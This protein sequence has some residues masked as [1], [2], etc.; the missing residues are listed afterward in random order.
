MLRHVIR[1]GV[2]ILTF[3]IGVAIFWPLQ[4]IQRLET[5][6]VDR[7]IGISDDDLKPVSLNADYTAEAN[8]VY[9][10]I[11]HQKFVHETKNPIVV[12]SKTIGYSMYIDDALKPEWAFPE[13]FNKMVKHSMPEVEFETLSNFLL[14]N[15]G[16]GYLKIWDRGVNY[17]LATESDLLGD[18]MGPFWTSFRKKFPNS[19]GFLSFSN[20]GFNKQ[21]N[22]A[23]VYVDWNCG[24]TCGAGGYILLKKVRGK[25]EIVKDNGLWFS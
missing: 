11:I 14:R 5:A 1:V 12:R 9:R 22:Q 19:G 6:L 8:E 16:G 3:T 2:A 25:W 24:P 10:L 7:F 15:R 13:A 21:H 23:F 4:L 18:S 17:V 20:V